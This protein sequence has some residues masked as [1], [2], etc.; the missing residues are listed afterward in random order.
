M[1]YN[2]KYQL[3]ISA[4]IMKPTKNIAAEAASILQNHEYL[5]PLLFDQ[6]NCLNNVVKNKLQLISETLQKRFVCFFPYAKV[7]D[8]VLAG[9][10]CSYIYND[11]SDIDFFIFVDNAVPDDPKTSKR[12]LAAID[13]FLS[14]LYWR[15]L[16][17]GH[18]VDF[19][20]LPADD[21]RRTGRNHYSL[22]HDKWISAPEH[23]TFAFTPE[24]LADKYAV[25]YQNL[26]Q[27][28]DSLEKTPSGLLT[29]QS[30]PLALNYL[31]NLRNQAFDSKEFF[32]EHEYC[33]NYN[34]YRLLKHLGA[35]MQFLNY[36]SDSSRAAG[37]KQP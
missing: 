22:L 25:Y 27:Y 5:S 14:T 1:I 21:V 34:L 37:M 6:N 26:K 18:P 33:E 4:L 8:V 35:Y 10:M 23:Q 30:Y 17:Y 32:K 3:D 31:Q 9:S 24:Q 11:R 12:L 29:A 13:K 20:I 19:G 36:I 16:F 7:V 28:I 15:P 2:N